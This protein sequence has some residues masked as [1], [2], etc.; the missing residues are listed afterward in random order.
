MVIVI[1]GILVAITFSAYIN[2][3]QQVRLGNGIEQLK[4]ALTKAQQLS[5]ASAEGNGWGLHLESDRYVLFSGLAYDVANPT[6]RVEL[7]S[8]LE[9]INPATSLSDGSGGYSPNIIFDKVTGRTV[10]TGTIELSVAYWPSLSRTVII[11]SLGIIQ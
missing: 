4:S 9:I 11:N 1:I 2:W 7:L 3:Q 8:G 5:V 10:N 6:N